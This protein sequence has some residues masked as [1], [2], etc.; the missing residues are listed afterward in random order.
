MEIDLLEKIYQEVNKKK[1][2]NVVPPFITHRSLKEYVLGVMKKELSA[3]KHSGMITL[4]EGINE[5]L[6]GINDG[7]TEE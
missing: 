2:A 6:I 4:H 3:L 7:E 1:E 5:W